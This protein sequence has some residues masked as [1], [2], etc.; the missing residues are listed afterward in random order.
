MGVRSGAQYIDSIRN[1]G[2]ALYIG[3]QRVEDVTAHPPLA[4][5]VRAIAQHYDRF[6]DPGLQPEY[7]YAS[8]AD[9]K[10]VSN[11]FLPATTWDEVSQRIRG[12]S[13]RCQATHGFM[14]RL[15][16]FMNAFVTDVAVV[17][18]H[19]LGHQD[20]AFADNAIRYYEYC[21]DQ[22]VCL[23]HTL[24][25]PRR[26]YSQ[27]LG[28]QRT[29][30]KVKETDAGIYVSGAR[31]LSTLAPV[32]QE[33]W[34]GPFMPRAPGE[35]DMALCFAVPVA[36]P[37]LK[38]VARESY[39]RGRNF[40]DRPLSERYDEGDALALFD[41]VFVPWER[42][43]IAGDIVAHNMMGPS[44]PGYLAL[45]ANIRGRAKL[46]FMTGL[47]SKVATTLGRGE[48]PRYRELLGELM[49]LNELADGLVEASAREVIRHAQEE[50]AHARDPAFRLTDQAGETA[51]VFASM[52][53]SMVS[54]AM[55]RFFLPLV[56]TKVNE[57]IRLMGS[58]SLVMSVT[59]A[60]LS[61]PDLADELETY[62]SG[63]RASARER[64]GVM[65]LAWD[66]VASEF[67]G[68]QEIYE[69][70]FAGDPFL[71]RQ[72]HYQTPR[73][74]QFEALVDELLAKPN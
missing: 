10:P 51:A 5:I 61:H 27:G 28:A 35:E 4:G 48:M 54:M 36:T 74:E 7:T 42:V 55:L 73:R 70:F 53:R 43:F 62:M 56:N 45:Q 40:F 47:A 21:R 58:S 14:G 65:K 16:D 72:L 11:S 12:E 23:T 13:A 57:V 31:M 34:V 46:R 37:G 9:G 29:V 26:D 67:G 66:A 32:S 18:P 30:R 19:I 22:D 63:A 15:P 41:N 59:D 25:D 71:S 2:R 1:D 38:F 3:G 24:A 8:P 39:A 33:L 60:D 17:A 6:S 52:S 49:G 68:R 69:I 44:Y 50:T 64:V 20:K